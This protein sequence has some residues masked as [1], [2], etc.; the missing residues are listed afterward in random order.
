MTVETKLINPCGL[1]EPDRTEIFGF[2]FGYG[3]EL[4][5]IL[6]NNLFFWFSLVCDFRKINKLKNQNYPNFVNNYTKIYQNP[7]NRL[8]LE[9]I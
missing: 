1:S 9:K 6:K 7:Q 4:D 2:W 8:F 5:M 3:F